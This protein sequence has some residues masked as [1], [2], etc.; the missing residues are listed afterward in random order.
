MHRLFQALPEDGGAQNIVALDHR[1]QRVDKPVDGALVVKPQLHLQHVG[2]ALG[3]RQVVVENAGLQ[4][5]QAVDVLHVGNATGHGLKDMVDSGLIQLDQGQHVRGY[6]LRV[7]LN[8]VGRHLHGLLAA[9]R[10]S[11]RRQGR[12]TEQHAHIG[13]EVDLAHA[14][15][16][17]DRQQRMAAE[18]EEI[19]LTTDTVDVEQV[20]PEH[21]EG[22]FHRPLGRRIL[23]P[24]HGVGIGCG[25]GLAV[26]FAVGGQR[27]RIQ[28]HEGAGHHVFGQAQQ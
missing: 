17:L 21:G 12:L 15:D 16:Q 19:V 1:V 4:R 7:C 27:Q 18:L 26:E 28:A 10:R 25:Q 14:F 5:R 11:E 8:K 20:L 3:G 13:A 22:G 6:G 2:V 23:A 24:G 9:H